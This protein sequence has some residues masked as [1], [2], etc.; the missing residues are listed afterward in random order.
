MDGTSG[1]G[2][3]S[4]YA[5]TIRLLEYLM[6]AGTLIAAVAVAVVCGLGIIVWIAGGRPEPR[7]K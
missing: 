4:S 5:M 2:H 6:L 3:E 7:M 1:D